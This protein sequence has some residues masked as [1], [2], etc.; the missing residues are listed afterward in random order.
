MGTLDAFTLNLLTNDEVIAINQDPIGQQASRISNDDGKQIWVKEMEDG[1]K[2]VGFFYTDD[3]K[4][5]PV[6]YFSWG[7]KGTT[8]ITM[9]AADIGI[10]GKFKV[11]DV[12][13][14]KDLGMF[15]NAF[16]ADVPY[17][18]AVLVVIRGHI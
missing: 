13:R 16:T 10:K 14:Q 5:N 11:R 6:D 9:H 1:S 8:K 17:H 3:G 4:R 15:E 7:K 2:A 12:W 18:G